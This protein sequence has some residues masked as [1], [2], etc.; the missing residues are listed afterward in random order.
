[1]KPETVITARGVGKQ[2]LIGHRAANTGDLSLVE[3]VARNVKN[4]W[5]RSADLVRG[6]PIIM[7]DEVEEVWALRNVDFEINAG[8][9]VGII[10][11]NGAGK[12]TLLKVLSR[13]T[14]PTE[15]S[16]E[17]RG[18]VASLLEV[19]TGFHPELSG[20]D[21]IYLNGGILGMTRVEIRKQF[22]S[23]VEFAGVERYIDTPVKR[24]S[25]GMYVRL[26]FAIAAH[27]EPEIMIID[28]VLAVGD[29]EFQKRCLGKMDEVTSSGR[30]ILFVSHMMPMVA[31]LCS[32]CLLME[33]GQLVANGPTSDVIHR[34][35]SGAGANAASI[36][37]PIEAK[38]PG[39]EFTSLLA[40]WVENDRGERRFE[41]T[42]SESVR[43]A[44]QY[45][46][47][48]PLKATPHPNLHVV[49]SAGNYVFVTY[50]HDW[51]KD[52]AR[53]PGDYIAVVEIPAHLLNDGLYSV[54][55]ALNHFQN[56]LQTAFFEKG[57]LNFNIVDPIE[58]GTREAS[59]WGGR[60]PG[61][62]RPQ[63]AWNVEETS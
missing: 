59:G 47:H 49:D 42:L 9:A 10:G 35:Q 3:S 37:F 48:A 16:I 30:T 50:P 60:I 44:V 29:I 5:H 24:Y 61:V 54:G 46:V 31:S 7:G 62:V 22:D 43:I 8:E 52:R 55:V 4:V 25:S 13:I 15:G 11:R 45:R 26:A 1:M 27:L 57:A 33:G 6:R 63:L 2:Y 56:G 12:S 17:I 23:I 58:T 14:D 40:A 41:Y 19:G 38:R 53:T 36:E 21:N 20:R 28:E 18:R 51:S 32:R 34:Y 39:D